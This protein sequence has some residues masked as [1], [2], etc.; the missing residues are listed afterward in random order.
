MKIENFTLDGAV[1]SATV[2]IIT[3]V[4]II[5]SNLL[6]WFFPSNAGFKTDVP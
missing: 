2:I 6:W 3:T 5:R 1:L 4:L